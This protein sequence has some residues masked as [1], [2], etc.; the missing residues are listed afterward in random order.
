LGARVSVYT[1]GGRKLVQQVDGGNG[2]SGKSSPDLLFG[3]GNERG[4]V[5]V[6]FDWRDREGVARHY[7]TSLMPCWH[8]ALLGNSKNEHD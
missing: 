1:L 4:R 6:A 7:E 5:R 8:T 2:H 3:L